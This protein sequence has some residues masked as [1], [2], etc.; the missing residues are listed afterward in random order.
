MGGEL[1]ICFFGVDS[2]QQMSQQNPKGV[3]YGARR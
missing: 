1:D 2:A 3:S